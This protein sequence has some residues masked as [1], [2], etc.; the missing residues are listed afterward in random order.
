MKKIFIIILIISMMVG[1]CILPV[2]MVQTVPVRQNDSIRLNGFVYSLPQTS[3]RIEAEIV[4]TR[5]I[6]GPYYRFAEKYLGIQN[7][8]EQSSVVWDL[9]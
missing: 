1:S 2:N 6:R 7:V 5:T 9:A 8:P 4:M 3:F